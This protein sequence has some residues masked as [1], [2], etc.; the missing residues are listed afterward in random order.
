M[1][2]K[3]I[4]WVDI[5]KGIAIFLMVC[6]HT[7]IPQSVSNWIWSFHMPLFFLISGY[8]FKIPERKSIKKWCGKQIQSL[9]IPCMFFYAGNMA[10]ALKHVSL[11][12]IIK[13]VVF[14]VYG[15]RILP[16]VYWFI[17]CMLLSRIIMGL[18][19][20][21]LRS[22]KAKAF[23]YIGMYLLSVV[24]SRTVIPNGVYYYPNVPLYCL[25]PWNADVC[26]FAIPF[27]AIGKYM[28]DCLS[29]KQVNCLARNYE[30]MML[31][32]AVAVLALFS[33]LQICNLYSIEIDMKYV[34]Y[35]NFI[36][37]AVLPLSAGVILR[38]CAISLSNGG[39]YAATA[40]CE[41]GK[42]SLVIMYIHLL[43]RDYLI[44]PLFGERYPVILWTL[45]TCTSGILIRTLAKKN[46]ISSII[47]L[48]K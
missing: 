47:V 8:L 30:Q 1:V 3:R 27:M 48:G 31:G 22:K 24:E 43:I 35:S 33:L 36:L 29:E 18:I 7:S 38:K 28:K 39:G 20:A 2:T 26:L 10:L 15:G 40:L 9:L 45:T 11:S 37:C 25:I 4:E 21:Y 34:H 16:G 17:S 6:G 13:K 23:I 46:R 41:I 5:T 42:A 12:D 14:F 44:I 32:V 19:E